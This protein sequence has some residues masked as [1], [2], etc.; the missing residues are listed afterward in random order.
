MREGLICK[1]GQSKNPHFSNHKH[2]FHNEFILRKPRQIGSDGVCVWR[3][4]YFLDANAYDDAL[5]SEIHCTTAAP[6]DLLNLL[7]VKE[8]L[9]GTF[10]TEMSSM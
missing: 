6:F 5:R 9:C 2:E 10:L 3:R 4:T 7:S 1:L 8:G